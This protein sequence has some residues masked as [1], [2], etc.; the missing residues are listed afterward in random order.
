[1]STYTGPQREVP[2]EE[3]RSIVAAVLS[4]LS[5]QW[6]QG[7]DWAY[8]ECPGAGCHTNDNGRRDCRVYVCEA[9]G[10]T[11]KPPGVY[12]L[13][14]SCAGVLA[15]VNHR[16][17]SAIGKAKASVGPQYG[18][19]GGG[20]K[21]TGGPG[22]E[23]SS[24]NGQPTARTGN[25]KAPPR[26]S[27]ALPTDRTVILKPLVGFAR[28]QVRAQSSVGGE[29]Q[30]SGP[31]AVASTPPQPAQP[32][33]ISATKRAPKQVDRAVALVAEERLETTWVMG[34]TVE[35]GYWENGEWVCTRRRNT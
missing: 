7:G 26:G 11:L 33:P 28:A 31:S 1:V 25:F 14:T 23:S 32:A 12:C 9:A 6:E 3:R 27:D 15:D 13:H 22:G 20:A 21:R 19:K 10:R 24:R 35:K 18:A 4:P 16:I 17:R 5:P 29:N 2:L 34:D 8:I 30:T